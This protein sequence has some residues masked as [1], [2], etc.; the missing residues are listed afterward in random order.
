[1]DDGDQNDPEAIK[2]TINKMPRKSYQGNRTNI[3]LLSY[4]QG[5]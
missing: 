1:M 2:R 4:R 3:D 5:A